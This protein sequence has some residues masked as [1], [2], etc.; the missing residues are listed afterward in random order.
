MLVETGWGCDLVQVVHVEVQ[1][2][3]YWTDRATGSLY[4][5]VDGHNQLHAWKTGLKKVTDKQRAALALG[6]KARRHAYQRTD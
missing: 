4:D 3:D 2:V 5:F 6:P 1:G